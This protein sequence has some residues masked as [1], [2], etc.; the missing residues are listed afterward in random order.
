[1]VGLHPPVP[2]IK[3]KAV[4]ALDKAMVH[5]MV[6]GGIMPFPKPVPYKT[7]WEKLIPHVAENVHHQGIKRKKVKRRYVVRDGKNDQRYNANFDQ[8][9]NRVKS[10]GRKRCGVKRPVVHHMYSF[11][12]RFPVQQT[13]GPVKVGVVHKYHQQYAEKIIGPAIFV[14]R[15]IDQRPAVFTG[16]HYLHDD[17]TKN[18]NGVERVPDFAVDMFFVGETLLYLQIPVLALFPNIKEQKDRPRKQKETHAQESRLLC[19]I[20]QIAE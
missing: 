11:V 18:E 19:R 12:Q 4:V 2:D 20:P 13:M 6:G 1:V 15:V 10:V 5:I 3:I 9:L 16:P 7:L 8:C 17:D 14:N